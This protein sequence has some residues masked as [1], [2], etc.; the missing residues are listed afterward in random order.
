MEV[1]QMVGV[2]EKQLVGMDGDIRPTGEGRAGKGGRE[3]RE[4]GPRG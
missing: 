1:R 3:P 4:Q 2:P